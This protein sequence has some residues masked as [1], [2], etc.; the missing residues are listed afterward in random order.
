M[1]TFTEAFTR[2]RNEFDQSFKDRLAFVEQVREDTAT[3]MENHRQWI[4]DV[5]K[6][7]A[8]DLA[9]GGKI[10]RSHAKAA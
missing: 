10:F 9:K 3:M 2:M 1:A 4:R 7:F 8:A 5:L 6:P